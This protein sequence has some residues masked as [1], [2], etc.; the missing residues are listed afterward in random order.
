[1]EPLNQAGQKYSIPSREDV[2]GTS[3]SGS[4]AGEDLSSLKPNLRKD[5]KRVAGWLPLLGPLVGTNV[6]SQI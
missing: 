3:G 1:M 6:H 5:E 2:A 4:L